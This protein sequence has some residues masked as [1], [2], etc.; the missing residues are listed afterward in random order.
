MLHLSLSIVNSVDPFLLRV[1]MPKFVYLLFSLFVHACQPC[2]RERNECL[3]VIRPV[4]E[5]EEDGKQ[6]R[7][8]K[9]SDREN[10]HWSHLFREG[11]VRRCGQRWDRNTHR[12]VDKRIASQTSK[13]GC[14][15]LEDFM[16]NLRIDLQRTAQGKQNM[17]SSFKVII[18]FLHCWIKPV[19]AD[20]WHIKRQ[21]DKSPLCCPVSHMLTS[22]LDERGVR[23]ADVSKTNHS[24]GSIYFSCTA[25]SPHCW[26]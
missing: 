18:L 9:K 13:S 1:R 21:I 22:S 26:S 16:N 12:N 24:R 23:Q 4:G 14:K 8:G 17:I 20:T 2:S 6:R 7:W 10:P 19:R 15:I 25:Q 11:L 5:E 3:W